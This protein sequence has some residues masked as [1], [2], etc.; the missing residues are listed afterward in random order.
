MALPI[1]VDTGFGKRPRN[2]FNARKVV[3]DGYTFDSKTEHA[4]YLVLKEMV[5]AGEIHGLRVHPKFQFSVK[6]RKLLIRST[7]FP[8]GRQVTWT[9]DFQY[10]RPGFGLVTE[11]VKGKKYR[12]RAP[13][14]DKYYRLKK[15]IFECL[16]WP[17]QVEEV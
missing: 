14:D 17:V 3:C 4:R 6:G 9:P 2:K 8:N 12:G 10:I 5:V 7:G 13:T 11:D 15:A 16:Y 1:R